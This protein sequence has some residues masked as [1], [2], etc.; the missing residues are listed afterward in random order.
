MWRCLKMRNRFYNTVNRAHM[1]L[2]S[3]LPLVHRV[4]CGWCSPRTRAASFFFREDRVR[5]GQM[6][7]VC[8]IIKWVWVSDWSFIFYE[9]EREKSSLCGICFQPASLTNWKSQCQFVSCDSSWILTEKRTDKKSSLLWT[10]CKLLLL[11]FMRMT[12]CENWRTA[13]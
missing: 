2:S 7:S 10:D 5:Q 11:F 12:D 8:P 13:P 1:Y 9:W 4:R 6:F 3:E